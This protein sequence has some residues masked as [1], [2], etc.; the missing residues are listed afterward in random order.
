LTYRYISSQEYDDTEQDILS[1][2]MSESEKKF[3]LQIKKLK[4]HV[5]VAMFVQNDY[6]GGYF[7]IS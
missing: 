5:K 6:F 2:A 3:I 1:S 7:C 4:D